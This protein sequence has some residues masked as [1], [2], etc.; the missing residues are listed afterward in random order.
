[1]TN[2]FQYWG[3][4]PEVIGGGV[5]AGVASAILVSAVWA[6][7]RWVGNL[8]LKRILGVPRE[9][10]VIRPWYD[11][12]ADGSGAA[13]EGQRAVADPGSRRLT[14]E[15]AYA[16]ADIIQLCRVIGARAPNAGGQI[17]A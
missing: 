7:R 9:Y 13:V 1:M 8:R 2:F 6:V 12:A 16:L 15:N 4:T 5:V 17:F 14:T 10:G 11:D 3:L